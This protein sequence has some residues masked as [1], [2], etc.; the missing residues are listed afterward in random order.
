MA[1]GKYI[2]VKSKDKKTAV[3]LATN[4]G[5]YRSQG[6][7]LSDPT[8]EEIKEYFPSEFASQKIPSKADLSGLETELGQVKAD[9]EN[10]KQAHVATTN[11]L[12]EEQNLHTETKNSLATTQSELKQAKTDLENAGN[13]VEELKNEVVKLQSEIEKLKKKA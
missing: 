7:E 11:K 4:E 9:L 8:E 6:Y 5:F 3:V 13:A 2:K 1:K 12:S 10:E